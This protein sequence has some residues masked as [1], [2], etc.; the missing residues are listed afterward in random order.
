MLH[1]ANELLKVGQ[2]VIFVIDDHLLHTYK[3]PSLLQLKLQGYFKDNNNIK[4]IQYGFND[5]FAHPLFQE[6]SEYNI[7]IDEYHT[8]DL[9]P[10]EENLDPLIDYSEMV[11]KNRHLWVAIGE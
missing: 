7:F 4:I 5:C 11:N 10:Q 9:L 6:Y 8:R 1:C 2:K 3:L